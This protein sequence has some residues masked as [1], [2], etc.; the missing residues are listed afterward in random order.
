MATVSIPRSV[1]IVFC[2]RR[3][4]GSLILRTALW[5][6]WSHCAIVNGDQVIEASAFHGVRTRPLAELEAEAS[7]REFVDVPCADPAALIA[8]ATAQLNKPYDWRGVFGLAFHRKWQGGDS[9]FCS[10]LVAAAFAAA[11]SPL[12]VTDAWR[13]TPRDLSI[14]H[15]WK[16]RS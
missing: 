11:G 6:A 7:Q 16:A 2:R 1:R 8:W 14:R 15:Y 10:E 3:N 12:F 13:I 5:S 9:W 4:L